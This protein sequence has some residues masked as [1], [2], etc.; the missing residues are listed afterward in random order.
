MNI[1]VLLVGF[2]TVFAVSLAVSAIVTLL[3]NFIVH[4]VSTV[5]WEA[6]I[7]FATLFGIILPWI[8]TRKCKCA[9]DSLA[10][11]PTVGPMN[12]VMAICLLL[13]SSVQGQDVDKKAQDSGPPVKEPALRLE[14]LAI[15]KLDQEIRFALFKRLGEKGISLGEVNSVTDPALLKIVLEETGKMAAV[16]KKNRVRLKEIVDKHGWP[17]TS[18][19]GRD[20]AHA[21]WLV[22]Q[23]ADADLAFQKDC[24]DLMKAAPKGEVEPT[25]VAYLTDRVLVAEKKKQIYGTQLDGNFVPRP[26]EDEANVDRRRA[27][28]GMTPLAEYLKFA[29]AANDKLSGKQSE[30][31]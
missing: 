14:L 19:V 15:E 9:K 13:A 23:H 1:K 28:V 30:K 2:V 31:K 26:I 21:A 17:G 12:V 29:K 8:G 7:G 20:A 18:L 22:A 6:S 3:W 27:E 16:D 24:L 11:L 10:Q 5:D 25:H 4:G